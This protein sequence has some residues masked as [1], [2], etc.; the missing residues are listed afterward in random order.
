MGIQIRVA[1]R[2]RSKTLPAVHKCCSRLQVKAFQTIA[3]VCTLSALSNRP[4]S[5]ISM[6]GDQLI[7]YNKSTSFLCV[8]HK[9]KK[10]AKIQTR[11]LTGNSTA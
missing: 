7:S 11:L 3:H 5:K 2:T 9:A 10:H 6:T 1:E 4:E 8:F